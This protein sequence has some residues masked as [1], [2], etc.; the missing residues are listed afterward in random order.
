MRLFLLSLT[1]AAA[2]PLI[3]A[4]GQRGQCRNACERDYD[5]CLKRSASKVARKTCA[6]FRKTCKRGCPAL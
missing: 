3:G 1:I 5:L 6:V 2:L 4:P